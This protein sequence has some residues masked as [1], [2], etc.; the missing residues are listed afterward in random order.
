MF[1]MMFYPFLALICVALMS[2]AYG[3]QMVWHKVACLGDA[4]SHGALLGLAF[5]VLL[6]VDENVALFVL[7]GIWAFFLWF[8]TKGRQNSLD[9]IMAFLMQ[10][11]MAL[12]IILF[13]LSGANGDDSMLHAFLGDVLVVTAKDVAYIAF[14]DI[15]LAFVLVLCW[16]KW[17]LMA[18]S[19]DLARAQKYSTGWLQ[20]VFFTAIGFFIAVTMKLMGALLAPAFFVIPALIARPLSKTPEK[21][22]LLA[23][24]FACVA[25]VA[26]LMISYYFDLPTGASVVCVCLCLYVV[27]VFCGFIKSLLIKKRAYY[28]QA[29][30]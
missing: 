27:V 29:L 21:M 6:G 11:S 30:K 22:A 2:G 16:K 24:V 10:A 8:L 4:L 26:G 25:S 1:E 20:F 12:A 18:I 17:V 15:V 5:G 14:L 23:T 9:T 13:A 28:N 7:S 19:M 3:C